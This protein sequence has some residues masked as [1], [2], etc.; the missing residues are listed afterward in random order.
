MPVQA[1]E[2]PPSN[3]PVI[4]MP[5][6]NNKSKGYITDDGTVFKIKIPRPL[7]L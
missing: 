5:T 6:S 1:A 7:V 4:K 2:V 3:I